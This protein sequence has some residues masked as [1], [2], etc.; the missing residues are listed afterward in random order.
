MGWSHRE[1]RQMVHELSQTICSDAET[2]RRFEQKVVRAEVEWLPRPEHKPTADH[3]G[4]RP[5]DLF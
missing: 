4:K 3:P 5:G 1:H 2:R